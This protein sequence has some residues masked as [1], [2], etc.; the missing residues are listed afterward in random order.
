[1]WVYE[2][3]QQVVDDLGDSTV[4]V[5]TCIY[6]RVFVVDVSKALTAEGGVFALAGGYAVA[7]HGAVRGTVDIDIAVALQRKNFVAI[8][9]ALLSLGLQSRLPVDA[10]RVYQFREEYIEQ[11]NLLAWTFCDP[12]DPTRLVDVLLIHPL[13]KSH[14]DWID[15][16]GTQIPVLKKRVLIAMKKAAGRPQDLEDVSALERIR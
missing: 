4:S 10:E 15:V 5:Y 11:R 13:R 14:V 2:S 7:L 3:C 9:K 8:E 1:M 12:D 6:T 16:Q